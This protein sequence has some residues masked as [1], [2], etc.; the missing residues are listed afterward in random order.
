MIKNIL[1]LL[2]VVAATF[3]T[4]GCGTVDI[5]KTAK[6]FHPPTD[7]NEVEILM[8]K[9]D[10]RPYEELGAI[11]ATGFQPSETAKMHNAL[12]TKAAPLGANAVIIT[13]SGMVNGGGWGGVQQYVTG[14]AIKWK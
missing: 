5:T 4:T 12:R 6:G 9:P 10:N 1:V 14:V 3:F 11:N 13:G 7:P 8:T 2:I